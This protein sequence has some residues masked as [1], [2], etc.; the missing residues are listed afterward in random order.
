MTPFDE[1]RKAVALAVSLYDSTA[2]G[3]PEP[4]DDHVEYCLCHRCIFVR[5]VRGELAAFAKAEAKAEKK[6]AK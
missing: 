6:R 5:G 3:G 4:H 1:L 2:G